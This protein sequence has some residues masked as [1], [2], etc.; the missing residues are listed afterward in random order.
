M[1]VKMNLEF[2]RRWTG[3]ILLV[4]VIAVFYLSYKPILMSAHPNALHRFRCAGI[5]SQEGVSGFMFGTRGEA[6]ILVIWMGSDWDS[7]SCINDIETYVPCQKFNHSI[8]ENAFDGFRRRGVELGALVL[9]SKQR[10]S[11][12]GMDR[13]EQGERNTVYTKDAVFSV[14]AGNVFY[15]GNNG[16]AVQLPVQIE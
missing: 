8:I 4:M 12:L 11:F 10:V 3:A 16:N 1:N 9:E 5:A 6:A 7:V 15:V 2:L 14:S 13:K